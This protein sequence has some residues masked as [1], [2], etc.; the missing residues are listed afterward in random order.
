MENGQQE[1]EDYAV[2]DQTKYDGKTSR[3]VVT[4]KSVDYRAAVIHYL[5]N[6]AYQKDFER[7]SLQ[8]SIF[9]IKDMDPVFRTKDNP[10]KR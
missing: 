6:R 3:E 8:K 9:A 7:P 2:V 4:H 1:D 10:G 5:Q